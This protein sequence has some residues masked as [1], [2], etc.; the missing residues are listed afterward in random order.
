[1]CNHIKPKVGDTLFVAVLDLKHVYFFFFSKA[2]HFCFLIKMWGFGV[3]SLCYLIILFLGK[4]E[5]ERVS[6]F[7]Q[8]LLFF[9]HKRVE[10]WFLPSLGKQSIAQIHKGY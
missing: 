4:E 9:L 7:Y 2:C 1:M 5:E 3:A 10:T 8:Q 6:F